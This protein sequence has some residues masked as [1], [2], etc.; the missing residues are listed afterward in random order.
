[1][2]HLREKVIKLKLPLCIK[3]TLLHMVTWDEEDRI[4]TI[5]LYKALKNI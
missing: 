3:Q 1:M 2:E 5:S 4:P